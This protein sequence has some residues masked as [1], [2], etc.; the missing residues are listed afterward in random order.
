MEKDWILQTRETRRSFT[1]ATWVPLRA[2]QNHEKG[3]RLSIGYIREYF[4]CGSVA[5]SPEHRK[6]ADTLG[7]NDIG[8]GHKPQPYA[9]EDGYYSAIDQYEYNDKEPIGVELVLELDQP[10]IGR[11]KWMLNPDLIAALRL[12]KDGNKWVRPEEDFAVVA[13]EFF[14]EYGQHNMIEIKLEFLIDYLAARGLALRLSYYRQRAENVAVIEGTDYEGLADQQCERDN[15][16]FEL[17]VR[18]LDEMYG[19]SWAGVRVWRTD[20]DEEEDV[21]VFGPDSNDNIELEYTEGVLEGPKTI[22]VQSEF[23]KEEWIDHQGLSKRVRG[24]V[25][26]SLPNFIVHTDGSRMPSSKLNYENVGRWLWF[27]PSVV[28]ELI[29]HR[30]FAL[31]WLTAE[32]GAIVSTSGYH[33]HF[34]I[35]SAD[36]LTIYAYDIARLP[37]WEQHVWAGHNV[38]PDGKV[39]PELLASQVEIQS[40]STHAVEY[41]FFMGMRKLEKGFENKFGINL[42]THSIDDVSVMQKVSRFHSSNQASLLQLAKEIVKVF[43][44]RLSVSDLRKLSTHDAKDK[45]RS[46]KL[47]QSVLTQQVGEERARQIFSP[48]VGAY[49]LRNGDAHPTS[50]KISDAMKLAGIDESE[51]YLRQGQQ[52]I[53]NVACSIGCI[54]RLLFDESE[55]S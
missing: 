34:G 44:D 51:S 37:S 38:P 3:H 39:S 14:D 15:G 22:R 13:R 30:G 5:F 45:L 33:T 50:S 41:L 54:E 32:T 7:W 16:R 8:I 49:E 53:H 52:L 17:L 19:G 43:S 28:I 2:H 24:D 40:T 55:N 20:V 29:G 47:L 25:D 42:F 35:N 12:I 9:Y 11:T 6:T 4:G 18:S 31:K 10:V 46:N 21:P 1:N 26:K 48:I 36:L 23:W 27:R